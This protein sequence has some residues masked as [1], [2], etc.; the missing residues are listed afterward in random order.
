MTHMTRRTFAS[1]LAVA[2]GGLSLPALAGA[3]STEKYL[4]VG[5]GPQGLKA[6]LQAQ[7]T[8]PQREVTLVDPSFYMSQASHSPLA[9]KGLDPQEL[10]RF[11]QQ[12]GCLIEATVEG[13]DPSLGR[14]YVQQGQHIAF[15]QVETHLGMTFVEEPAAGI[16]HGW[17]D[18]V[19]ADQLWQ[20]IKNMKAG[21]VVAIQTPT[22]AYRYEK[23]PFE[24]A[25][26]IASYLETHN[27]SA[28]VFIFDGRHDK[29]LAALNSPM[30]EWVQE[31]TIGVTADVLN[32]IPAHK[33][34]ELG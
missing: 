9:P 1:L 30:I 26:I 8:K 20:Q 23:G 13:I 2:A 6:A 10:A 21:G 29:A 27:P 7:R 34:V 4:V 31:S 24:R 25:N 22:T 11:V 12:G 18:N 28:K 17:S 15:D 32:V 5:A 19:Q 14:A 3:S 16:L 33:V